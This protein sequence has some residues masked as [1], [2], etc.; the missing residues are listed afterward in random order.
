M[1]LDFVGNLISESSLLLCQ[2]K[3][4]EYVRKVVVSRN[5]WMSTSLDKIGKHYDQDSFPIC[6][7]QR[8]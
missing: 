6:K 4:V 2:L 3:E 5:Q 7:P 1:A 8:S